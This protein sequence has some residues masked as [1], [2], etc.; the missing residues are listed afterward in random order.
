M[1]RGKRVIFLYEDLNENGAWDHASGERR[2]STRSDC[3]AGNAQYVAGAG[4]VV[5]GQLR[6]ETCNVGN[7]EYTGAL[8]TWDDP[9]P[10]QLC[11]DGDGNGYR[12]GPCNRWGPESLQV[13]G[14]CFSQ[15]S[16][17]GGCHWTGDGCNASVS[18]GG[19]ICRGGYC[20]GTA[21]LK[22][23][24]S[25]VMIRDTGVH[26]VGANIPTG[27]RLSN[28]MASNPINVNW[29]R[30]NNSCEGGP[31]GIGLVRNTN[32]SCYVSPS[33]TSITATT[34]AVSVRLWGTTDSASVHT[35][36][37]FLQT[38]ST[39]SAL[40]TATAIN[41]IPPG[42]TQILSSG[43][44][45]YRNDSSACTTSNG[46]SCTTDRV[47]TGLPTGSYYFHCDIV[48]GATPVCS[49]NP[50]CSYEGFGGPNNCSASGW[51]SCRTPSQLP[52]DNAVVNAT[53]VPS[54]P[55]NQMCGQSDGCGGTC[56]NTSSGTPGSIQNLLPTGNVNLT[57]PSLAVTWTAPATGAGY[58][59]NYQIKVFRQ[60]LATTQGAI[61]ARPCTQLAGT[62]TCGTTNTG[63][64]TW[65][66]TPILA[67]TRNIV[68]AVRARNAS[69]GDQ[70]SP[71]V[72]TNVNLFGTISGNFYID[73]GATASGNLCINGGTNAIA[74]GAGT[75]VGAT[76]NSAAVGSS[77]V[78]GTTYSV[79]SVPYSPSAAWAPL[80][81][82]TLTLNNPDPANTLACS[83]PTPGANPFVCQYSGVFAPTANV[84]WYLDRY[85]LSND[86]WWQ[87]IGG[88][89]YTTSGVLSSDIPRPCVDAANPL[90][91]NPYIITR[92][93]LT[94]SESLTAGVPMT[95]GGAITSGTDA[96]GYYTDR[97]PQPRVVG[98]DHSGLN[99]E[100]YDFFASFYDLSTVAQIGAGTI[101]NENTLPTAVNTDPDGTEVYYRNGSLTIGPTARWTISPGEK[102]VI[103]VNGDL[104][105]QGPGDATNQLIEIT[106]D[107]SGASGFIAFIVNGTI[108]FDK[109]VGHIDYLQDSPPVVEGLFVADNAIVIAAETDAN[110]SD[111]KFI[112]GGTF[113]A[114]G[115]GGVGVDMPR[116]FANAAD[117]LSRAR[118]NLD[119]TETFRF[120]PELT[121]E[122]PD[123][124]KTPVL[125]WQEVN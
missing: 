40:P 13:E 122:I 95:G 24:A 59:D 115:D 32:T 96:P 70:S 117:P 118:N 17:G 56:P 99:R 78:A 49:G 88:L 1:N 124:M 83:C 113:V 111:R 108:T 106:T 20:A 90:T 87:T 97:N 48:Q 68:V 93:G 23:G 30:T 98:T 46:T 121:V 12:I 107:A 109:N 15:Q 51:K 112:G 120:M 61:T 125:E 9:G 79:T 75:T 37:L 86:P 39:T 101:S 4:I 92:D 18:T 25:L 58:I 72:L 16:C 114:W 67:H 110:I 119:A 64:T 42:F 76:M 11:N 27:W 38:K 5:S 54:C 84:N 123:K 7:S 45:Y 28:G 65:N 8:C 47:I 2:I 100:D 41:P 36:R 116:D 85:D 73:N 105:F 63:V 89:A 71:W 81:T 103:F 44:Y 91:C 80:T 6:T 14:T 50:S 94:P 55:V 62:A 22:S 77:S 21:D 60:G 74:V 33:S 52:T 10:A 53:C 69:C 35:A 66:Y 26:T 31:V 102:K 19:E 43:R 29:S 104:T 82:L 34:G 3:V 57:T